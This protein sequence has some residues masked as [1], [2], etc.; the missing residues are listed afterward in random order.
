MADNSAVSTEK[1]AAP[2]RWLR[3]EIVLLI[4]LVSIFLWIAGEVLLLAFGGILLAVGLDGLACVLATRTQ[5]SRGWSLV[6]VISLLV[7]L[8]GV[9]GVLLLPSLL[10]QFDDLFQR[11]KLF[12]QEASEKLS[13]YGWAE[14]IMEQGPTEQMATATGKMAEHAAWA[15]MWIISSLGSIIVVV[16]V[17]IFAVAD[18][19][20]YLRG[21]LLLLPTEYHERTEKTIAATG[22][23]LRWWFLG[24]VTSMIFL[25]VTVSVGLMLLGI[26]LWLSLGVLTALL[27]FIPFLGPIIAGVPIVII[28]FA[29]GLNTGIAVFAFYLIVQNVEGNF[30]VPIIQRRAVNLAPVVLITMQLL[31]GVLFGVLGVIMAA[32]L[33]AVALVAVR[34]LYVEPI[35]GRP[36]KIE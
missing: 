26:N 25:G 18:P 29:S 27:T 12:A 3:T 31:M 11:L 2:R 34:H 10:D 1:L 6:I 35:L 4:A 28:G 19:G 30:L 5:F 9:L 8:L 7:L 15:G 23:A 21:L 16:A 14:R 36:Q 22:N 24:Q 33:T 13:R 17:A 32:P 20:L